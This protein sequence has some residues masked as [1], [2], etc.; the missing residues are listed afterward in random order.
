MKTPNFTYIFSPGTPAMTV[1]GQEMNILIEQPISIAVT[2]NVANLAAVASDMRRHL[3]IRPPSIVP[4]ALEQAMRS[5]D[6]N[7]R[8]TVC[9]TTT[10]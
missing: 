9:E 7:T 8:N 2:A 4:M 6:I 3:T 10:C 1:C 5:P